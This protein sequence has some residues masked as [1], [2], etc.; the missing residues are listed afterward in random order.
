MVPASSDLAGLYVRGTV[1]EDNEARKAEAEVLLQ[2]VQEGGD[3]D[4][5]LRVTYWNTPEELAKLIETQMISDIEADSK[6]TFD[7][8]KPY[9]A[10]GKACEDERRQ[11]GRSICKSFPRIVVSC[12]ARTTSTR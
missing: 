11:S 5:D 2:R 6:L 4:T 8:G 3:I 1:E 7:P 10:W 12:S 9:E